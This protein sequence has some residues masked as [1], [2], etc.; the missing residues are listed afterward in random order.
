[1]QI[2]GV[3]QV[4]LPRYPLWLLSLQQFDPGRDGSAGDVGRGRHHF[5]GVTA[6]AV[7]PEVAGSGAR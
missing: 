5:M 4:G 1:M 7:G 6:I 2:Y 3:V